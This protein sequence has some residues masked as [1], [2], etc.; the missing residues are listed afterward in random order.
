MTAPSLDVDLDRSVVVLGATV[1]VR[2]V[3][4]GAETV[5][6]DGH[7][8]PPVTIDCR[9]GRAWAQVTPR[10]AGT[11]RVSARIG[12]TTVSRVAGPVTVL[13]PTPAPRLPLPTVQFAP[14]PP[15]SVPLP[16]IGAVLP[17]LPP[18][19]DVPEPVGLPV[20]LPGPW[21]P[22]SP[23]VPD[24][25]PPAPEF[26]T[27]PSAFPIDLASYFTFTDRTTDHRDP[28]ATR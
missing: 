21:A 9:D 22:P 11:L 28:E 17:P 12:G 7:G 18:A 24:L 1:T 6:I 25:L 13:D 15:A 2:W 3:A 16:M 4:P 27:G 5:T 8:M 19:A 20:R 26:G 14:P 23:V 10:T